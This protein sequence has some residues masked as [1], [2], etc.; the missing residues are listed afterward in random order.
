MMKEKR[1]QL[2]VGV[3]WNR[4]DGHGCGEVN[5]TQQHTCTYQRAYARVML[6]G[7]MQSL[8]ASE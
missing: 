1:H 4:G 2:A 5:I 6:A 8:K 3:W 7:R